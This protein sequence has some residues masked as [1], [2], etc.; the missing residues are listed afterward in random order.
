M[1]QTVYFK[2]CDIA[3][4]C[5]NPSN[6]HIMIDK[7]APTVPKITNSSNGDWTISPIVLTMQSSDAASGLADYQYSYDNSSW[8][9]TYVTTPSYEFTPIHT[10]D[11]TILNRKIYWRACDAVG[12]CSASSNTSLKIDR[13]KPV[14]GSI[15]KTRTYSRDGVNGTIACSDSD[16]GC[17]NSSYSFEDLTDDTDITIQDN[18]GNINSC[19]IPIYSETWV[20]YYWTTCWYTYEYSCGYSVSCPMQWADVDDALRE[21]WPCAASCSHEIASEEECVDH[22]ANSTMDNGFLRYDWIPYSRESYT[23]YTFNSLGEIVTYTPWK[24]LGSNT[25]NG[26]G[27]CIY[28]CSM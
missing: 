20:E 16:S 4:N 17:K 26:D 28:D 10:D 24:R 25:Y 18:V 1:N 23:H 5:S 21:K 22:A 7:T 6:T 15:N 11:N 19:E 27:Y 2:V 14:C 9:K 3:G 8:N 12:N 13:V